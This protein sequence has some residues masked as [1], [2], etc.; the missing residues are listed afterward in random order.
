M[1]VMAKF[2]IGDLVNQKEGS[3]RNGLVIDIQYGYS[4]R[5]HDSQTVYEYAIV[6]WLD[7]K[8]QRIKTSFLEKSS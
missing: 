3:K 7:G 5:K 6:E 4:E 2:G 1:I 8:R